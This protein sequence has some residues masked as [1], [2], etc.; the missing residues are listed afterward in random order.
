MDNFT[1]FEFFNSN[2]LTNFLLVLIFWALA[3]I[4]KELSEK[5]KLLQNINNAVWR[6]ADKLNPDKD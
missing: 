2:L 1:F 5:L 4:G 6:T 3:Q